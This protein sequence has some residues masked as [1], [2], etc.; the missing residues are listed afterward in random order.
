MMKKLLS[1]L[2]VL[3]MATVANAAMMISVDGVVPDDAVSVATA[4]IGVMASGSHPATIPG[5]VVGQGPINVDLTATT[6]IPNFGI[7]GDPLIQDMTGDP[8][9]IAFL[10]DLGIMNPVSILY[11]EVIDV[12]VPPK[13]IPDGVVINSMNLTYKGTGEEAL[14]TLLDTGTG[15]VLDTQAIVPEPITLALLGL[16]GLFLRRRK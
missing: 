15:E 6:I 12:A 10:A 5:M 9:A 4:V 2:A 16:G 1:V 14:I 3:A 11:F 8:D 7:S 13:A